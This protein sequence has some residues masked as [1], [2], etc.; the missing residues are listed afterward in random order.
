ML[1]RIKTLGPVGKLFAKGL[2][3][4]YCS[5]NIL[6][7]QNISPFGSIILNCPD[8]ATTI[9]PINPFEAPDGNEAQFQI[10]SC[11]QN[12]LPFNLKE[13]IDI[14]YNHKESVI[15]LQ[16]KDLAK[17]YNGKLL[18]NVQIPHN[19][20]LD[21]N[22][23]LIDVKET[24]GDTLKI[25]SNGNCTLGKIKTDNVNISIHNGKLSCTNLFG[26]G[27]IFAKN[28]IHLLKIQSKYLDM[29]SKGDIELSSVYCP[30]LKCF[31]ENGNINLGSLHG[32]SDLQTHSGSISISALDGNTNIQTVSGDVSATIE[33]CNHVFI[34]SEQGNIS[35]GL[36]E[37][38]SAFLEAE[39]MFIDVP[40]DL[41]VD[42]MKRESSAGVHYFE[43]KLGSGESAI[44]I[45]TQ[46]GTVDFSRRNWFSKFD[47]DLS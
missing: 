47:T 40:Q 34:T 13:Y 16:Q 24:E 1:F 9:Q 26:S 2:D 43:G 15:F 32:F 30:Q 21:V 20:N 25:S 14:E 36:S 38:V 42:G 22:A 18:L 6:S 44:Q 39:G 8:V 4:S 5:K 17:S 31:T 23:L 7:L 11:E 3:R 33:S 29:Y 27:K 46:C 12:L 19:Y 35:V 37:A 28:G 41:L 10:S 45:K